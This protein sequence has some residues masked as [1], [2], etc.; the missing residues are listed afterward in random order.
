MATKNKQPATGLGLYVH[1]PFC[2]KKCRYCDFV[3]YVGGAA[4]VDLYLAALKQE[5]AL[6]DA[7]LRPADKRPD[8]IFIGGGTP[9]SLP[10][11]KLLALL[12]WI[13]SIFEP[14][15]GCEIT[16]EA[17][18]GTVDEAYLRALRE[19]GVNRL[20]LGAQSFQDRLLTMLGRA[21]NAR[22]AAEAVRAARVA[23]FTNLSLD[24][25]FGLPTQTG[26]DL[27][28]S[29][30][31]AVGL[32]PTHLSVYGLQ[33]EPGT[34]L[35]QAVAAKQLTPCS[36][37]SELAM[38]QTALEFLPAHGYQHYEISNFAQPGYESR[39]NLKYWQ[40]KPYLGLG[41]AAHAYFRGERRANEPTVEK[42]A[43]RLAKGELPVVSRETIT[44]E[45]EMA[46]TMLTGLR[47]RQGVDCEAFFNRF[48]RRAEAI[49]QKEITK[50]TQAGLLETQNGHLRLTPQGLPLGNLVFAE[51]V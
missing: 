17:N 50:L 35:T 48:G 45:I 36:E 34:P 33:L 2:L 1:V 15:P 46:E 43:A 3:S 12:E 4:A 25:M 13:G 24:L 14:V 27:R 19:G 18:P 40:N 6:Y 7:L 31:R 47:L 38:Y 30:E 37:D 22:E 23:G 21:H 42:Y 8:S 10:A 49:Y 11:P 26:E 5:L 51:F 32:E 39:H 9:T 20:S 44:P 16:V 41:P 29:L 28:A